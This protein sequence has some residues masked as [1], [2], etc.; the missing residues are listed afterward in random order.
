M[1]GFNSIGVMKVITKNTK[2]LLVFVFIAAVAS[3]G[4]SF[5]LR[6]KY[7]STAVV[8]PVNMYQNSEESNSEQL[9][10][11]LLSE[12]VKNKLAS[13]FNL[14]QRYGIDTLEKGGRALFSYM[15]Q[16][17]FNISPTLYESIEISVKDED[18]AMAKKLNARLIVLTNKL[19]QENKLAVI[20]QYLNNAKKVLKASDDE[21]D[22][23]DGRIKKIKTEYN[24]V[25]EVNQ[26][27]YIS[28]EMAKGGNF[29][30]N[31][32]KQTEGLKLKGSELRILRGKIKSTLGSYTEMKVQYDKYLMDA[33][34]NIDFILYVSKPSLPDKRCYPVRWIIVLVSSMSVLLLGVIVTIIRNRLKHPL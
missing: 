29:S 10:Q 34:G 18:P 30:E 7:K 23:L 2:T 24:I 16:E 5:L 17:N 11:Y 21:L 26:A 1:E 6:D 13:E 14:Y 8:Y 32:Q 27:K 33:Q 12:E 15:Y 9:L 3:F 22:S 4:L 25:D 20:N 31:V 19:I 28:K